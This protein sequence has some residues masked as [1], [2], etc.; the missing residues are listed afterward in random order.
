MEIKTFAEFKALLGQTIEE[1]HAYEKKYPDMPIYG[2][3]GAQLA[4]V[5]KI[6]V[7]EKRKP[8]KEE[9]DSISLGMIAVKNFED[10]MPEFSE[11]LEKINYAFSRPADAVFLEIGF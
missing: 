2:N 6:L 5:K 4:F 9:S 11:K 7:D 3:I 1:A 10:D 8:T